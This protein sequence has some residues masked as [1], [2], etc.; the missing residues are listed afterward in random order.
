M[1]V[2]AGAHIAALQPK[3]RRYA[4][5]LAGDSERSTPEVSSSVLLEAQ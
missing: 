3:I 2:P 4:R 5:L 1:K